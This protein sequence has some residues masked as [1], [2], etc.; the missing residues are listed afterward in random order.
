[1]ANY[2]DEH[3]CRELRDGETP[4]H[5][6]H[7]VRLLIDSGNFDASEFSAFM[8]DRPPPP[9]S[10]KFIEEQL[11]AKLIRSENEEFDCPVCLKRCELDDE[12]CRLPCSHR[13][14]KECIMPWLEKTSSCPLCRKELPTDDEDYEKMRA[15]KKREKQRKEDLE[16]LHSSMFG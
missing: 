8:G 4:D 11:E 13:F 5:M 9:T 6:M 2:F 7:F 15:H 10:K 14:H 1:M 16:N 3:D 12:F